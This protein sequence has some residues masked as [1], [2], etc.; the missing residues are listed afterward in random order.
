MSLRGQCPEKTVTKDG[1]HQAVPHSPVDKPTNSIL[2]WHRLPC[3]GLVIRTEI[4]I[5]TM[6]YTSWYLSAKTNIV[7]RDSQISET[8]PV[9]NVWK[10]SSRFNTAWQAVMSQSGLIKQQPL[11]RSWQMRHWDTY[12][13]GCCFLTVTVVLSVTANLAKWYSWVTGHLLSFSRRWYQELAS[14]LTKPHGVLFSTFSKK[15]VLSFWETSTS[16]FL[17]NIIKLAA[18]VTKENNV[19]NWWLKSP[20]SSTHRENHMNAHTELM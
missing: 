6:V 10:A 4:L 20:Q 13:K 2:S 15:L 16:L 7:E 3:S 9:F 12:L 1:V 19:T 8:C 5:S 17:P 14:N 11:P 18:E